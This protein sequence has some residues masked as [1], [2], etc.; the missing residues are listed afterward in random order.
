MMRAKKGTRVL[1]GMS[2]GVDSSVAASL[3]VKQGY[4]VIGGFIKNWSDSRNASTGECTWK[5]DRRDA[6]RVAAMLN[7][8][9]VTFDFEKIFKSKVVED[10]F[11]GYSS[12]LTPNPDVLCNEIIKFGLFFEAA[13]KIKARFIATGH[14]ARVKYNKSGEAVLLRGFDKNKDQSY[15][16][17]RI[18]QKALSRTLFPVGHMNKKMVRQI[19]YKLGLSIAAKPDSQ[20]ICFIGK[21]SLGKFLRHRIKSKPGSIMD[22]QGTILGEHKGLDL[23]TIGQRQNIRVSREGHAWFVARKD[24]EKNSLTIV[25]SENHPLLFSKEISISDLRW[26]AGHEPEFPSSC[27][28]QVRYRQEPIAATVFK[29]NINHDLKVLFKK[30]V[31]ACAPGQ[32]AVI[33]KKNQ[34]LGGG[35]IKNS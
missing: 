6:M 21:I 25:P 22:D 7:I 13:K 9:L 1:V 35:I 3:L 2:G 34:C 26:I 19:A 8:P 28:V 5:E 33:Y 16:L 17:Y 11:S 23:Y 32:S 10:L 31:K 30:P 14:Y 27:L 29:N 24:Y 12:G 15:F 20:G 18:S 4:E